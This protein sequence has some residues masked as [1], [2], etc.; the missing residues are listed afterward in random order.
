MRLVSELRQATVRV[1]SSFEGKGSM[2]DHRRDFEPPPPK[3][4]ILEL[5][6]LFLIVVIAGFGLGKLIWYWL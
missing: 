5:I 3:I 2:N 4:P 6:I 1:R